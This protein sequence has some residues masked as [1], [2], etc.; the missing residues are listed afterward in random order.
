M[1]KCIYILLGYCLL[2]IYSVY[3]QTIDYPQQSVLSSGVWYSVSISSDGIYKLTYNDFVSLGVAKEDIDFDNLSIYGNTGKAISEKNTEYL[4]SDLKENAIYVNKQDKYVLFYAQATTQTIYDTNSGKFSFKYHPYAT[5]TKYFITFDKNIGE[6]KRISE[7]RYS[8]SQPFEIRT[9]A[10]DYVFYKRELYNLA[11][12]GRYWFG[13]RFLPTA[14]DLQ[15]PVNLPNVNKNESAEVAIRLF[16]NSAKPCLYDVSMNGESL[17]QVN[18]LASTSAETAHM[19]MLT[20]EKKLN[21]VSNSINMHF[22][23]EIP[24]AEG[25]LDYILINYTKDL[26]FNNGYLKFFALPDASEEQVRY[27]ISNVRTSNYMVW[28]VTDRLNVRMIDNCVLKDNVLSV[29]ICSDTLKEIIVLSG[30]SFPTPVLEDTVLNQNLHGIDTADFV[31]ITH[32]MFINQA[33]RLAQIHRKYDNITVAVVSLQQVYNEFSSGTKDFLAFREFIRMMYNKTEGKYPKNVLLFGDGTFD[34]KNILHYDNNYVPTYQSDV[35][36]SASDNNFTSDDVLAAIGNN[37][38]N[39]VRDSLFVGIGRIPVGDTITA[40]IVVDKCERYISKSD[41][42]K[43]DN[44]DWRNAVMLTSDD[45][46]EY[47]EKYFRDNAENIYYQ[48]DETNPGLNVQKVYED[49]YK[50]YNS[51]SG[52]TYPDASNAVNDRMKKGCLLFNYLG[53]GSPDHLSSERLITIT[54]ITSWDNY[55]KLCL[56]ITSTCEF[57]RFDLADKQS[58]GEYILTSKN[59]AGIGLIAAARKISSNN[60]INRSLFKYVLERQSDG[61]P[62]TF[63]QVMQHAKNLVNSGYYGGGL[64]VSERSITFI[65]DPAL[66]LS[67]PQYNV[68]TLRINNSYCNENGI[69]DH[70]DTVRALSTVTVQGEITDMN[71]KRLEDFNGRIQVSL[72]DKKTVYYMLN[73][74]N[75]NLSKEQLA[76]EQQNNILH[77]GSAEVVNGIFTHTFTVPKD[78]AYNYGYGKLSYYA[79]TDSIDAAGYCTGFIL[80]GIDTNNTEY[81]FSR[82]DISLY[83]NDTNFVNGGLCDEN[84]ALYAVVYD[85]VPINTVGS[86]LGHDIVARLDNAANTFILNDYYVSDKSNPNVGYITYPFKNLSQGEHSLNLKVWNIYNLSSERTINFIVKHSSSEE[87]EAI[88]YPN[89]FKNTTS[90][91]LRYNQPQTVISAYIKIFNSHGAIVTEFDISDK[92]GDYTVGPVIW[93]GTTSG[94]AKVQK[95]LYFYT[96]ILS[97]VE[98]DKIVRGNKM[99]MLD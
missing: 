99:I 98:G 96:I 3:S 77:K 30:S 43:K 49:A 90:I 27:D 85:T 88:S 51:S 75:H 36:N 19:G 5:E 65:G 42:L 71:G 50:E 76:F 68:R 4:Y 97:T 91:E 46:D 10:K 93:N 23:S 67:L 11:K 13:E 52:S 72:Y 94:G 14:P 86:G 17:G 16:A 54:D 66:R 69:F 53:H 61:R 28:D 95:G 1:K 47:Y 41:I 74:S 84:P 22:V 70:P 33:E 63:G 78:I 89:P 58:A 82:P 38:T 55:D 12:S 32:P 20:A 9:T 7:V 60:P 21:S 37:A 8:D 92:I 62:L 73:N 57:N 87:Y 40:N 26:V 15:I 35:I 59:G 39:N 34:N 18:I 24:I 83:L 80:G 48:I 45:M 6:K 25:W 81:E 29:N 31:I 79:Q 56:M 2:F 44:G 64:Q